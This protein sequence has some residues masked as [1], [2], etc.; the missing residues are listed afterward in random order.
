MT[1]SAAARDTQR[2]NFGGGWFMTK[3][4]LAKIEY[5]KQTYDGAGWNGS[6]YQG[7]EFNGVVIEA[8]I[9]F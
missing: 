4:V 9:G 7:A 6:Q 1:D 2:I 8:T 5:V 3:N